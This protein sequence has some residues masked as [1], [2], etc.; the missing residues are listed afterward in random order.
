MPS[1]ALREYGFQ[2]YLPRT[3]LPRINE[4][5]ATAQLHDLYARLRTSKEDKE[6]LRKEIESHPFN[7]VFV[8]AL[9]SKDGRKAY[10]ELLE[11]YH[12]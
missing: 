7:E 1:Q 3:F 4:C 2:R 12:G 8:E 5:R 11:K 6:E 10:R 9:Y